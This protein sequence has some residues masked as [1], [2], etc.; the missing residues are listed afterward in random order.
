MISGVKKHI[1][2][3]TGL[4]LVFLFVNVIGTTKPREIFID[5]DGSGHYAYL[6]SII[7]YHTVDFTEVFEYEK[8]RR[9][10]DYMGHYFHYYNN[11]YINKYTCG[12]ALLQLP[13]YLIAYFLS[14]ILGYSPDG[15][16]II[17]QFCIAL[18]TLFYSALGL[19]FTV[20][21]LSQWGIDKVFGWIFVILGLFG[22]N[23]F[24]YTVIEPSFTHAYSF[25]VITAF[26]FFARKTFT[27]YSK[28]NIVTAAFLLGLVILIRPANAIVI[29][30][31]PFIAG[32]WHNYSGAIL[33]KLKKLHFIPAALAFLAAL[34]PQLIINFLQTGHLIIYGYQN[35]GFYFNDPQTFNFLF[36]YRKGWLVYTPFF[37]LLIPGL[38]Y[39][40]RSQTRFASIGLLIFIGIQVYIFSSWW[41]W[42]Y[43]DSFGMRPMVDYY[44]LFLLVT[45]LFIYNSCRKWIK[46]VSFIFIG[47]CLIL[48][49]VQSY[50]YAKG[51][52]HPDSMSQE[53]YWYVFM[54]LDESKANTIAGCDESYFGKLDE[55][56]FFHTKNS[57]DVSDNGWLTRNSNN[58]L[59]SSGQL[60]YKL[61]PENIYGPSFT[62]TIP[63]S[64]HGYYNIY[65]RFSTK[66]Y[67]AELNSALKALF[68]VDIS[69]AKSN[70]FYKAFKVKKIPNQKTGIWNVSHIGF[71]LPEITNDMQYIKLYI[72]NAGKQNFHIDDLSIEFYTYN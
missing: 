22:T 68:V 10:P 67:E 27:Q 25:T 42:Y 24:F 13:F 53:A 61:S 59:S 21:L 35:E 64:L 51:I 6:P 56:P 54:D 50:Q 1:V 17:F 18:S 12:T 33:M 41:N 14:L 71:K 45:G 39:T 36:S 29:F 70:I 26:L 20:R 69:D 44:G 9:P 19:I 2:L 46:I 65:I 7:N 37:L 62:F 58:E 4:L 5:G 43:G 57:I 66:Y 15:Y 47:F 38:I 60:S 32:S 28:K 40:L 23:L 31:L 48:N 63:D 52:I 49:I 16:N 3:V 30:A 55:R 72:W 34:S 11:I 8:S